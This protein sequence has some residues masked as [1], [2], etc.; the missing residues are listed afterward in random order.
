MLRIGLTGSIASGKSTISNV[1]REN[2]I[3][4]IDADVI[5]RELVEPGMPALAK[6]QEH[7]GEDIFFPDGSLNRAQL[8]SIVFS[9]EDD[10]LWLNELLHPLIAE[11]AA[12]EFEQIAQE[13]D[14]CAV[15]DAALLFEAKFDR[16]VDKTITIVCDDAIR[17]QRIM[18]RD[19]L[20]HEEA[21][22]RMESQMPQGQKKLLADAWV[23]NSTDLDATKQCIDAILRQWGCIC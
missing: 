8:G 12:V 13:G 9:Q 22:Q 3:Q 23:D 19:G 2:G 21:L 6:I 4:V 1:F 10:R 7:F 20:S 14:S 15:F 16:L 17:I 11:S 18:Q 5:S